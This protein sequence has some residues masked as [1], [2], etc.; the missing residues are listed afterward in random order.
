MEID[1]EG[2]KKQT[3]K[4]EMEKAVKSANVTKEPPFAQDIHRA[5]RMKGG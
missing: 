4:A 2:I 3:T 5:C 1:I